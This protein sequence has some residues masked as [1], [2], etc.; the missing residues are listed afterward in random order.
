VTFSTTDSFQSDVGVSRWH[1]WL[2]AQ[3]RYLDLGSGVNQWLVRPGLGYEINDNLKAWVG[4]ARFRTRN[5]AG[6]VADENRY[7]QQMD[8]TAGRWNGG[9]F[10]MR[11]RLEQRSVSVGD[12]LGVVLRFMTKYVRP[13]GGD[14]NISLILG[15]EPFVD[16]RDTDWGGESGLGQNRSLIGVGWRLGDSVSV[17]AGYMNQYIWIDGGEDRINHLGVLSFKVRL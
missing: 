14:H 13:I 10:T 12:D 3:A 6:N 7:W 2:D 8:W 17:E 1:Y 11:A 4:Y 9:K 16:L 15:L 5:R